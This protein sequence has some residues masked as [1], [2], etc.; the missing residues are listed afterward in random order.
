MD[1][2]GGVV[3]DPQHASGNDRGAIAT[4]KAAGR[5][6]TVPP[7]N[8]AEC[9]AGNA[10]CHVVTN[11]RTKQARGRATQLPVATEH[12]DLC[13]GLVHD[14]EGVTLAVAGRHHPSRQ[15][16]DGIRDILAFRQ[17]VDG[18]GDLVRGRG[19]VGTG[20]ERKRK[21]QGQR[22]HAATDNKLRTV[23]MH[24]DGTTPCIHCWYPKARWP[25]RAIGSRLTPRVASG[26]N[27][28]PRGVRRGADSSCWTRLSI[29]SRRWLARWADWLADSA[30]CAAPCTR[31]SSW[32]S[33]ELM[34]ANSLS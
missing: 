2:D 18:T 17:Q 25:S 14:R 26:T 13:G 23:R 24:A 1:R 29:W 27:D 5:R 33:R 30:L 31:E 19:L 11:G 10:R 3:V 7:R 6:R 8:L 28:Q 16:D 12:Q 20:E 34:V 4:D 22:K 9:E 15:F 32:S 21:A